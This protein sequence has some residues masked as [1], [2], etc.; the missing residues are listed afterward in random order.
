MDK[1]IQIGQEVSLL[2]DS[3]KPHVLRKGSS[4]SSRVLKAVSRTQALPLSSKLFSGCLRP[5]QN[6]GTTEEDRRICRLSS[7][8]L[9]S[10]RSRACSR[11]KASESERF[12]STT[13]L[14]AEDV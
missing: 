1:I 6:S 4:W 8:Q 5:D 14:L 13:E 3:T 2:S 9:A 12:C 7:S 10:T 11:S